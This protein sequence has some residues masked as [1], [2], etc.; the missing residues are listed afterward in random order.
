MLNISEVGTAVDG[1][2]RSA[3]AEHELI[4]QPVSRARCVVR[5]DV[6]AAFDGRIGS[7]VLLHG[8][9][10]AVLDRGPPLDDA[11]DRGAPTIGRLP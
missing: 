4:P 2:N 6:Y 5:A 8:T 9:Q 7:E 11:S 10:T 3:N 1:G